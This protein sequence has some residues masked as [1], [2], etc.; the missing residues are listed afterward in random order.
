LTQGDVQTLMAGILGWAVIYLHW[1][2]E[3]LQFLILFGTCVYVIF[4]MI[5]EGR[6]LY[7]DVKGKGGSENES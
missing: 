2:P 4:R 1:I 3:T 7:R 5:R 6:K